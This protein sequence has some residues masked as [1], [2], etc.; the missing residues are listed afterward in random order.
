MKPSPTV[1]QGQPAFSRVSSLIRAAH[2]AVSIH[3]ISEVSQTSC[4]IVQINLEHSQSSIKPSKS[5][6]VHQVCFRD[7]GLFKFRCFFFLFHSFCKWTEQFTQR[8]RLCV[9]LFLGSGGAGLTPGSTRS[10]PDIRAPLLSSFPALHL[11]A[12]APFIHRKKW[13]FYIGE[14]QPLFFPVM[15][16]RGERSHDV[17]G[18]WLN[19]LK[20]IFSHRRLDVWD[21]V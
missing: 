5:F 11:S 1:S 16:G 10:A 7:Q 20:V 9:L 14:F 15:P 6:G 19:L 13:I 4:K 18:V 21:G 12:T 8:E 3:N 17:Y 2:W